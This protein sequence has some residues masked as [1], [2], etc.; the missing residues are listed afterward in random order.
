MLRLR[1][2]GAMLLLLFGVASVILAVSVSALPPQQ[3]GGVGVPVLGG[4][5]A[6]APCN[7]QTN[8]FVNGS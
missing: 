6:T 2:R 3:L 5:E 7:S 8:S 4:V 1:A